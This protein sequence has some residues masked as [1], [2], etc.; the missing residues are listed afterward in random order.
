M[1]NISLIGFG[2]VGSALALLLLSNK[3]TIR[4]N[5]MD[6]N[7]ACEGAFLDL[8]HG[9]SLYT[10][11]ELHFNREKLFLKA[12]FIYYAAGV[13][14]AH[15]DSR[16]SKARQNIQL[17][18]EIFANRHFT[19]K[20]FIIVIT[21][22]VDVVAQ[23]VHQFCELPPNHIIGTGTFLDQVRLE[24]YLAELLGINQKDVDALVVGEHGDTQVP[25]FSQCKINGQPL[26][27]HKACCKE[28][29][30][31][32]QNLTQKAAFKIRETQEGTCYGVSKCA[33]AL[34]DYLLSNEK[35]EL[36]LSVKTNEHYRKLLDLDRDIYIGLPISIE[37]GEISTNDDFIF[38][39]EELLALQKS[40]KVIA[41][42]NEEN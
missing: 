36:T 25:V 10:N 1:I 14:N 39:D 15:G 2:K 7:P 28:L 33:A 23:A 41:K 12:D 32:A 17:S 6:P 40:S 37:K 20:P 29:L 21:N 30:D 42:V 4:L 8:A 35:H 19:Q 16:L 5:I 9:A 3:H 13:P 22:P 38:S 24:Y 34:L 11:K 27:E 31:R 26:K 18:K